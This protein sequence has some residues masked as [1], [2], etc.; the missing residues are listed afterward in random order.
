MHCSYFATRGLLPT[1]QHIVMD[2]ETSSVSEMP[3]HAKGGLVI[4][5]HSKIRDALSDLASRALFPSAVRD[6]PRINS[7]RTAEVKIAQDPKLV[8]TLRTNRTN[9]DRGDILIQGC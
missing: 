4:L 1:L 9:K 2:A 8:K 5:R 7:S 6:E 3:L